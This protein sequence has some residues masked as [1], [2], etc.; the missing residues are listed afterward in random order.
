M[1]S[2]TS[3]KWPR[4]GA[5]EHRRL[6]NLLLHFPLAPLSTFSSIVLKSRPTYDL[7]V[8]ASIFLLCSS[9]FSFFG[10]GCTQ[11]VPHRVVAL[12]ARAFEDLPVVRISL[13]GDHE[14]PGP[15]SRPRGRR[16]DRGTQQVWAVQWECG[17]AALSS[18][19]FIRLPLRSD[20]VASCCRVQPAK[21]CSVLLHR[22]WP[23]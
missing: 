8:P 16:R 9:G 2:G 4:G 17:V 5:A 6:F 10:S 22:A 12:M 18:F 20:P 15:G 3:K 7:A 14:R 11:D 21:I 13:P 1:K 19:A 23:C